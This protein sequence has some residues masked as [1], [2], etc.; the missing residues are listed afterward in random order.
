MNFSE[1]PPSKQWA[2]LKYRGVKCADVWFKP[3]GEPFALVFRIPEASFHLPDMGQLLTPDNLLKAVG[4]AAAEVES[5]HH[6]GTPETEG[7]G[8]GLTDPLPPPPQGAS[9]LHLS[10]CLKPPPPPA[11]EDVGGA[12]E[13]AE[14]PE[15]RWQDLEAR[16][17]AIL[18]VEASVDTLR[19]SMEALRGEMEGA[20]RRTLT[21][22]EKVHAMN[23][24][25]A[26]W[27]KAK[28]RIIHA[29]PKMRDFIH[30]ATWLAGTPERKKLEEL[31]RSHVQPRVPFPEMGQM[32][33]LMENLLKDRQVLAALGGSVHQECKGVCADVQ[34][35]LRT[36]QG[37]AVANANRKRGA[38]A[39]RGKSF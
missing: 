31:Y 30:R 17:N 9:H 5:W 33:E 15:E 24:D 25:V 39:A 8:P 37:H 38:A 4:L 34:G 21:P 32:A 22:D 29:L 14:V 36:L 19:I 3:E 2:A 23:A 26:Q 13:A 20:S 11:A 10:V 18:V 27:N 16:W 12:P 1:Q 35:A 6:D 28:S 7:P